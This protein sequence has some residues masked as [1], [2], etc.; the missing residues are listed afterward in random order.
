MIGTESAGP[1]VS[2]LIP[3]YNAA[4]W[5]GETLRCLSDQTYQNL[6]II[7]VDDGSSDESCEIVEQFPQAG[8]KL[9]RQ[10]NAGAAS[11]RNGAMNASSGQFLQ[12]LDADDLLAPEKIERQME[13]LLASPASIAA[14]QWARFVRSPDEADFVADETWQSL[15]PVDWLVASWKDGGGMLFPAMWLVPRAVAERAGP[16]NQ[17]LSLND[18][19]EYFT[20]VVLAADKVIFCAGAR[21]YYRSGIVGSLS[22]SKSSAAWRS[23][24]SSIELCGSHLL[25]AEDSERTRRVIARLWQRFACA[26]YPYEPAL[27]NHGLSLA[28]A[29]HPVRMEPDGG[30]AFKLASSVLGWRLA[31]RLQRWSGRP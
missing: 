27:A 6:E 16:W 3:C 2:V 11:A 31:R 28:K 1:L 8:I 24:I 12:F 26:C 7:V 29:L 22:G 21:C 18:D 20:R 10:K 13:V 30:P 19:G 15:L 4:G 25:S 23:Q 17:S 14:A 9:I 5:I